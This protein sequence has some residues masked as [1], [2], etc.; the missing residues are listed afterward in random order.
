MGRLILPAALCLSSVQVIS[1][2]RFDNHW[3]GTAEMQRKIKFEVDYLL[4][5]EFQNSEM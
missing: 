3:N 2:P 5:I 1:L 4:E